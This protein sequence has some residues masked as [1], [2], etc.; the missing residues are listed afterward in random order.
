MQPRLPPEGFQDITNIPHVRI[1]MLYGTRN[2]FTGKAL[3]G[4]GASA[5]WMLDEAYNNL[6]N[7]SLHLIQYNLGLYI[8][9]AYRPRRAT[10][11]MLDWAKLSGNLHLVNEGYIARRSRHNSGAAIDLSLY[12]LST[13]DLLDMGTE[14]DCFSSASHR[15]NVQ[16]KALENRLFLLNTMKAYGFDGYDKE[17]WH[18]ELIDAR[19]FVLRDVPYGVNESDENHSI[20]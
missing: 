3:P 6:V 13:G 11:A 20:C 14:W 12:R 9:D 2:N 19:R 10:L 16:G 4:Y 8:W 1:E 7:I 17:W 5:A 18:F 15:N